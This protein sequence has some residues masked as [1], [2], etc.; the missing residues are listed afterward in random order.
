[1]LM[2]WTRTRPA[3]GALAIALIIG[4][5]RRTLSCCGVPTLTETMCGTPQSLRGDARG[6]VDDHR[7]A[8]DRHRA[9]QL[10]EPQRLTEREEDE[11]D[12]HG[13]LER[14]EDG[15]G[16]RPDAAHPREEQHDGADRGNQRREAD[17][18]AAG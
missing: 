9:E 13:R 18:H 6:Q 10:Y 1:M 12:R 15:G 3:T 14:R 17:P 16:R 4:R 11:R 2:P 5:P 7:R 8:E